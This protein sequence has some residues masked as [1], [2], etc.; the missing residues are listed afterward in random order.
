MKRETDGAPAAPQEGASSATPTDPQKG[1][2]SADPADREVGGSDVPARCGSLPGIEG[3]EGS[4]EGPGGSACA[5]RHPQSDRVAR[6]FEELHVYQRAREL[7]NGV[8][9]LTRQGAFRRDHGLADQ[10]RRA[11][12]S[13]MSNIAEGFERGTKTEFIQFL[14]IAKGSCGEVRAQMQVA[15]D[16]EYA[17]PAAATRLRELA[18]TVSGMLSN[19][20][21]H[22]QGSA[23]RGEKFARPRRMAAKSIQESIEALQ[24]AQEINIRAREERERRKREEQ[25]GGKDTEGGKV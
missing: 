20:I 5:S 12:V 15:G 16:Q 22:L 9:A 21:A 8:Y 13:V 6:C 7:T 3:W 4:V 10:V 18:R 19:L 25:D 2:S 24:R 11:A 14:Y 23:Y 17:A 1:A